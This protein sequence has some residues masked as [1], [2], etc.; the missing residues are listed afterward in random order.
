MSLGHAYY[1][2]S[3][4]ALP[5]GARITVQGGVLIFLV[6]GTNIWVYY[7]QLVS[8]RDV[9]REYDID[10]LHITIT[11]DLFQKYQRLT[12]FSA[13][14]SFRCTFCKYNTTDRLSCG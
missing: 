1:I 11:A 4:K 8:I 3:G 2:C 12:S 13:N 10:S 5:P 7:S 14:N 6:E 9:R